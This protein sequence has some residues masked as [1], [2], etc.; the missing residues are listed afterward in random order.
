MIS[1]ETA[2]H[3]VA[4]GLAFGSLLAVD[5]AT[6][7]PVPSVPAFLLFYGVVLGG[8]HFYLAVRGEDGMVPVA[9][10]WRYVTLLA[11]LF[12]TGAVITY[13]GDRTVAAIEIESIGTA[14]IG[15]ALV[16]YLLTESIDGYRA[17]RT[18]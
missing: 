6:D 11:V 12:T 13:W 2:V 8:A 3:L 1:R 18:E 10:R 7:G 5:A 17:S 4:V 9:S 16:A 15:L 14:I